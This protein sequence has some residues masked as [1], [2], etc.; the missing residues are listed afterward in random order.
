MKRSNNALG[1][2]R[3]S[4]RRHCSQSCAYSDETTWHPRWWR[5]PL[6]NPRK[7]HFRDSKFQ[8][9]A[10]CHGPQELVPWCEFQSRLLSQ[11]SA[12][13][14]K[15][16]DSPAVRYMLVLDV[17]TTAFWIR[18][19]IHSWWVLIKLFLIF[20]PSLASVHKS[21]RLMVFFYCFQRNPH[22]GKN[23]SYVTMLLICFW[24]LNYVDT[25]THCQ[26]TAYFLK[27]VTQLRVYWTSEWNMRLSN[28]R[29]LCIDQGSIDPHFGPGP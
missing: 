12:C 1:T 14:L 23:L 11:L 29:R 13:Y 10:K 6:E 22:G 15:L 26:M 25:F 5:I 28:L 17:C 16:F 8:N 21:C 19:N 27:N 18:K 9:V 4:F 24:F 7:C 20:F 3:Q 2:F